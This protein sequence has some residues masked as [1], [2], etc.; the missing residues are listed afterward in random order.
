MKQESIKM[1][2]SDP[3]VWISLLY[4]S[5]FQIKIL[6]VVTAG[7]F[8]CHLVGHRALDSTATQDLRLTYFKLAMDLA[9]FFCK[10]TNQMPYLPSEDPC[11]HQ[12]KL[13]SGD[14]YMSHKTERK[15]IDDDAF[16]ET[17]LYS[18]LCGK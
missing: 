17:S 14:I 6:R 10:T 12:C 16:N 15:I 7:R 5:L 4:F 9:S 3:I 1:V 8:Y 11:K 2:D 13:F 18:I